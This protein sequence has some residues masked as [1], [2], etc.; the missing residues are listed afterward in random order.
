MKKNPRFTV[1]AQYH[2][3]LVENSTNTTATVN[4]GASGA[5]R[6]LLLLPGDLGT[7]G[8]LTSANTF[9]TLALGTQV[10]C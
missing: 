9:M 5:T 3:S 6:T 10:K 7:I 8:E 4:L 2:R 1:G